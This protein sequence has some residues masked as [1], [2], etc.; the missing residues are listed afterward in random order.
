MLNNE[1]INSILIK[2]PRENTTLAKIE[3]FLNYNIFYLI[4]FEI[5]YLIK[6]YILLLKFISIDF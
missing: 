2:N 1:I 4:T 6:L 5:I 3:E